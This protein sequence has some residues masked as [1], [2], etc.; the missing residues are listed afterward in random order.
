MTN[1]DILEIAMRQSAA[2]SGCAADDFKSCEN[3]IVQSR[4]NPAARN[5]L[6][7]PF[8]CDFTSYGDNVVASVSP[9][10][11]KIAADYID[12]YPAPRCFE[13]PGMHV[14]TERLR[15]LRMNVCFMAEYFLPDAGALRRLPC[16]Y[17]IRLLEPDGFA[18][19]YLPEWDNALS[20][21]RRQFDRLAAAAYDGKTLV[22]LAGCSAD[23]ASMWQIGVDVLPGYR[24]RG[25]ASALTSALALE[26][27]SR[28]LVPFYCCAWANIRS[29]RNA[30]KSGF[31]PAW[32]QLTVKPDDFVAGMN[33]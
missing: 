32:A 9:E 17:E 23:C 22:G 29:A 1:T 16:P 28:N 20:K 30:V 24:R 26:V 31:R 6:E 27:L 21:R 19:L 12:R 15:P 7:L 4:P 18:S 5:Y 8:L 14:L 10:C 13:T 33:R 11:A 3:K 2:D 25:V